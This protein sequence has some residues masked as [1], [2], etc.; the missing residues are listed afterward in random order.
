MPLS[1]HRVVPSGATWAGQYMLVE[2]RSDGAYRVAEIATRRNRTVV[3]LA[4][5]PI[6]T[7][8]KGDRFAIVPSAWTRVK[9]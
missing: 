1:A 2:G 7:L 4:D 3:K 6:L 9:P 8:G 5:E